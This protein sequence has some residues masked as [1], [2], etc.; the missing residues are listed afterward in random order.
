MTIPAEH[1]AYADLDLPSDLP[2]AKKNVL[3]PSKYEP[4]SNEVW[5]F[6]RSE[7]S[8]IKVSVHCAP[9]ATGGVVNQ[10]IE[11]LIG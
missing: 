3:P 6:A 1:R 5:P 8:Q 7:A 2:V 4:S 10:L 9:L 11:H